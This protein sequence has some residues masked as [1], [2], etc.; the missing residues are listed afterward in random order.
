MPTLHAKRQHAGRAGEKAESPAEIPA[1]GWKEIA[2]RVWR[3]FGDHNVSL[4]AAG[5]ALFALLAIFPA[6]NV[7]VNIYALAA[8]PSE[9]LDHL[10]PI[11]QLV[12]EEAF[13]ILENQLVAIAGQDR[14]AINV[15]L[16]ASILFGFWSARKGA[17]A[18][19]TACNVAYGEHEHRPFWL[20]ILI[21]FL[22]TVAGIVGF[23]VVGLVAILLPVALEFLPLNEAIT[24]ALHLLRWPML[25]AIFVLALQAVYRFAPCRSTAKW[26]WVSWGAIIATALWIL[27]SLLFS[28]YVRNFGNYNETYGAIGGV[29]ILI[30]WFD[31]SALAVVLGAE[32]NAE[33]EHQTKMDSTTGEPKPMGK[34]GAYVADTTGAGAKDEPK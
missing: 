10:A 20:V 31:I 21:S 32:I 6:L 18:L 26:R 25:A 7:S 3:N 17:A 22:F 11:Q 14:T 28:L 19:I 15:S 24:G 23:V 12:P 33:M 34:R 27:A 30:L 16:I 8:S 5:V 4:V 29:I 1:R 2:W 13:A 9:V